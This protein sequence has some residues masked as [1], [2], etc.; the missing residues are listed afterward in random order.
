MEDYSVIS[1]PGF[2]EPVSCFSHLLAAAIILSW[3][4]V[5]VIQTPMSV[6][7]RFSFIVYA[8]GAVFM[9]AMSGVYH[10][11][12]HGSTERF[13]LQRLDHA[14]IWIMIAATFTPIQ[15][16]LF[17]GARRWT[18]LALVWA[19]AGTGIVL[20]TV[21]FAGIPEWA[22]LLL[23]LGMGWIGAWSGI[24][25]MR[26]YGSR[27]F[28]PL[29]WG[30]LL[31]TVGAVLDYL[32]FPVIIPGVVGPHEVFHIFVVAGALSHFVLVMR[33]IRRRYPIRL[34]RRRAWVST[35]S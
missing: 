7:K 21:F 19:L 1:I 8:C 5:L 9:F 33:A 28:N 13:V 4:I 31:Y 25:L 3:S 18:V 16:L 6:L 11:L 20:K 10:L 26:R 23:Y 22:G 24:D 27:F 12:D 17:R 14:A 15:L 29:A 2:A 30:G 32:R 35:R 34:A